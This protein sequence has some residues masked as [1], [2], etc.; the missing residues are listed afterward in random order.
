MSQL[1]GKTTVASNSGSF[2]S[3]TNSA[4][5]AVAMLTAP[6]AP[7]PSPTSSS[8]STWD[9]AAVDGRGETG[10][11]DYRMAHESPGPHNGASLDDIETV[12]PDFYAHPEWYDYHEPGISTESIAQI[13]AARGNPDAEVTIYRSVPDASMGIR[14]GDW[15]TLSRR[16]AQMHGA[17]HEDPAR[18]W[19]VVE[20]RVKARDIWSEGNDPNEFGWHPGT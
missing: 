1:R 17:H 7:A 8:A 2:A 18:D 11:D 3:K 5:G 9:D 12:M 15:V 10:E 16:Y 20:M 14:G 13:R 4:P 19:P 6:E